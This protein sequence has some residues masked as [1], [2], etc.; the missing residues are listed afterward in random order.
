MLN[1]RTVE[2]WPRLGLVKDATRGMKCVVAVGNPRV[3][4]Q[5]ARQVMESGAE[6]VTVDST[7]HRHASVSV[8]SGGMLVA[9]VRTTVNTTIGAHFIGNLNCTV[10]HDVRIGEFVTIAP[11][12]AV[13]GNVRIGDGAEIGTGAVVRE[14]VR[15]GSGALVGMG[16]VVVANVEPNTVVVGNPARVLK[17]LSPW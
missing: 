10:G 6:F 13:S 15:V 11:L 2:G 16:A 12:A 17:V 5:L 8:A 9:G 14:G 4:R 7:P 3:R 1:E